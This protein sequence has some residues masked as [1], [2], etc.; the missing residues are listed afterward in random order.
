VDLQIKILAMKYNQAE[1][2]ERERWWRTKEGH[3][4]VEALKAAAQEK[5]LYEEQ[6]APVNL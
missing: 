5:R 4:L 1:A 6:A 2:E 3:R